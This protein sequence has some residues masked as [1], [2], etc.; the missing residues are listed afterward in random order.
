MASIGHRTGLFDVLRELPPATSEEIA[1]R[2]GLNERY[3]REWLSAMVTAGVIAVHPVAN[4]FLLLAE[5]AAFLTRA[6]AADN[7]AVL[8]HY[9]AV[10][11]GVEDDV[12]AGSTR[13]GGVP[14]EKYLRFHEVMAE[15]SG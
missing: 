4:R 8:A 3:V 10:L 7:V 11:H 1:T 2:A 15:D 5:Y 13:G 6:A 14:Y 9:I 12:V